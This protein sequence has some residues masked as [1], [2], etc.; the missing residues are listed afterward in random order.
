M[1]VEHLPHLGRL[2]FYARSRPGRGRE[3]AVTVSAAGGVRVEG[4]GACP[5]PSNAPGRAEAANASVRRWRGEEDEAEEWIEVIV[6]LG[7][8]AS[9][10]AE[11]AR[12]VLRDLP[13]ADELDRSLLRGLWC[14]FCGSALASGPPSRALPLPSPHWQE[15]TELW[16]CH[17]SQDIPLA[18]ADLAARDGDWLVGETHVQVPAGAAAAGGV[19][20]R[21]GGPDGAL[22]ARCARCDQ[23]VGEA[24]HGGGLGDA[25]SPAELAELRFQKCRVRTAPP[26]PAARDAFAAYTAEGTAAHTLVA[27]CEGRAR[28]QFA[29]RGQAPGDRRLLLVALMGWEGGVAAA[30]AAGGDLAPAVKV[31]Y[32]VD[33]AGAGGVADGWLARPGTVDVVVCT[34]ET[35]HETLRALRLS[36]ARLPPACRQVVPGFEVGFLLR[37]RPTKSGG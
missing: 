34:D 16:F 6:P 33:E 8:R 26:G 12:A 21:E 17:A 36:T 11:L 32:A 15:L 4:A 9:P 31:R 10:R 1:F 22:Q 13:S 3:A 35:F 20:V 19:R 37:V 29:L 23:P 25:A 5:F 18:S 7:T 28:Y 27:A 30:P 14:A 2:A 24:R